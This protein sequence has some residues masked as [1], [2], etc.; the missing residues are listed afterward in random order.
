MVGSRE[1]VGV[2]LGFA[3]VDTIACVGTDG[4]TLWRGCVWR[5]EHSVP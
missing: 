1:P 5:K 4:T 3:K 2:E